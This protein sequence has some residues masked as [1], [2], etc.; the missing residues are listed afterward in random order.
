MREAKNPVETDSRGTDRL[1]GVVDILMKVEEQTAS[2]SPG[3]RGY[4]CNHSIL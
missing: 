4:K 3:K 2:K 1:S